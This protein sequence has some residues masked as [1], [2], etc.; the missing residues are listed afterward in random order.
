MEEDIIN[1]NYKRYSI[2]RWGKD[3]FSIGKNG[4]IHIHPDYSSDSNLNIDIIDVINEARKKGLQLPL[5]IRFKNILHNKVIELNE[6]FI[7]AIS[8]S[9]YQS[10]Y[11]GVYPIKVN[12]KHDV[13]NEI[14]KAGKPYCFGLEA[15]SKTE[16]AAVLS[17]DTPQ[18]SLT[19]LNG[20]KD[21]GCIQLAL[22]G[23]YFD[24]NV[25]IVIESIHELSRVITIS[26]QLG[27][28]PTLGIRA[29]L[30]SQSGGKWN[31]SSGKNAK[32]GL[33]SL[34][35][36]LA[37]DM[38][39]NAQ[40]LPSLKLFHFHIGSQIPSLLKLGDAVTEATYLYCD[41]KKK[42][43]SL[44][45]L[46]VGGGLAVDYQDIDSGVEHQAT[47]N[48]KQYA[49]KIVDTIK[50]ICG[51]TETQHPIIVSESGRML[52]ASH[53]CVITNVFDTDTSQQ[54]QNHELTGNQHPNIE[55]ISSL[56]RDLSIHCI[57]PLFEQVNDLVTK[58]NKDFCQGKLSLEARAGIELAY[59]QFKIKAQNLDKRSSENSKVHYFCN[60][61][62]FQSIPDCWAIKQHLPVV[63][64]TH[65]NETPDTLCT[66][67]DITCDSDGAVD[68]FSL[69]GTPSYELPVHS[70]SKQ[71][72]YY[73]GFFLTGAY[74]DVMSNMHN[75]FGRVNEVQISSCSNQKLNFRITKYIKGESTSHLL[76]KMGYKSDEMQ[77]RLKVLLST[78]VANGR[79]T[80]DYSASLIDFY[81]SSLSDYPYLNLS[82]SK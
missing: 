64:L 35:L 6:A 18:D 68:L 38:L 19:I 30:N 15:G 76:D 80:E 17:L 45:Y 41:L 40:L 56:T 77:Q 49:Y 61:S 16:L 74:Q 53:A 11:R 31:S 82:I 55:S 20:Y 72:P 44:T 66:I 62:V 51:E 8:S 7:E 23:Q 42:A 27:I 81:Y 59:A 34:E 5:I 22:Y 4:H 46:D 12:Q 36:L 26:K 13:V 24:K 79:I 29:K 71:A 33:S 73:L 65:L 14:I 60:F 69:D 70:I 67:A 54:V 39:E 37:I 1:S 43:P 25:T 48:T 47:Y 50:S 52:T 10:Q 57:S 75:L 9:G 28:L 32:F 63:P 2:N 78:K 21:N 3:Y 58:A